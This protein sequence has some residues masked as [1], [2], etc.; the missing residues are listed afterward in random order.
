MTRATAN[1]PLTIDIVSDV[2]C[3]W[4]Y[5]GKRKLEAALALPE[6]ADLPPVVIRWHPFQLNPDLPAGGMPRQQYLEDKFGGPERAKTIYDRVR[7]AGSAVGLTLNIDGIAHQANTLAAHALIAFAQQG[8][9]DGSD[10]KERL[11]KAYFV[12]NR[13]IGDTEVLAA[14]AAEA[15]LDADAARAFITS[16]DER[17][18]VAESDAQARQLGVT[19]VPFFIFNRQLAVSGAQ[20]PATLLDAMKQAVAGAP[21]D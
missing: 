8:D 5:I 16:A 12:E 13:N 19:G 10:M 18:A 11:L 3:P 2:V 17:A 15:G 9:K 21:A 6:A 1:T 4:C 20:D 7:A 14:I